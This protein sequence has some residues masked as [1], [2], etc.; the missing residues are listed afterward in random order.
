YAELAT[1]YPHAGGDYHYLTRAYG[2]RLSFLFGWARLSVIQT[3]SIAFLAFVFGDYAVQVLPIGQYSAAIYAAMI[4]AVLT[5]LV[6]TGVYMLVNWA[7][8][9]ALGLAGTARSDHVAADVMRHA[10]GEGGAQAISMLIAI[11]AVTSANAAV[12]TGARTAYAFGCDFK[13]FSFL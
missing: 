13:P 2:H 3:G 12:F 5:I 8:L 1:T 7:Y 9:N 10:F 6:I 4:V 11:S